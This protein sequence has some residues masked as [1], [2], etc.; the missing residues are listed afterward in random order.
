MAGAGRLI[1][2]LLHESI[3]SLQDIL[4]K[5]PTIPKS[6][7]GRTLRNNP[8]VAPYKMIIQVPKWGRLVRQPLGGWIPCSNRNIFERITEQKGATMAAFTIRS[9]TL[10]LGLRSIPA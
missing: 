1:H 10:Q 2:V 6:T 8:L 3:A 4:A 5:M 7:F 9:S